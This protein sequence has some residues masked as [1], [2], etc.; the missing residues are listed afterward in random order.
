VALMKMARETSGR[1]HP[2][3]L[4]CWKQD[5]DFQP[6]VSKSGESDY[7]LQVKVGDLPLAIIVA[8]KHEG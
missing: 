3:S 2:M 7:V 6:G 4:S 5:T 1:N 8:G